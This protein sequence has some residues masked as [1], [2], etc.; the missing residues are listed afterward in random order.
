MKRNRQCPDCGQKFDNV[1]EQ[2]DHLVEDEEDLFDPM[3]EIQ[4]GYS[5]RLGSL[6]RNFYNQAGNPAET[7]RLAEETFEVLYMST[8]DPIKFTKYAKEAFISAVM[9]GVDYEYQK[10]IE[11]E[12]GDDGTKRKK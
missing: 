11:G 7:R 3:F 10:L 8:I 2:A 9:R 12:G 5:L 1:F 6:L 4:Q